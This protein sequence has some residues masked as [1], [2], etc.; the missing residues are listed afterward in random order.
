MSTSLRVN[1]IAI[2][3]IKRWEGFRPLAYLCPANVWSIGYGHTKTA[4]EGMK[5]T[6]AEAEALLRQDLDE[7]V[8]ALATAIRVPLSDQQS[9]AIL[10]WAYNV[11]VGAAQRS[12]L[13]RKLNAGDYAAVPEELMRWVR[14]RGK[15]LPGLVNRRS[16]EAGLWVLGS[17]VAGRESLAP[18]APEPETIVSAAGTD[19]GKGALATAAAAMVAVLAQ[20][21]PVIDRLGAL[22]WQAS[23]AVVA[24]A[25]LAVLAWRARRA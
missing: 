23:V 4:R 13:L 14:A 1:Q 21:E 3:M 20:A 24:A 2:D 11:G 5:V 18:T 19:T 8:A 22:P 15:V 9:A 12:T 17:H 10:S 7:I 6:Q 16:A 25:A